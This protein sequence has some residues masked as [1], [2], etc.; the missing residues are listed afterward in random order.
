[1]SETKPINII[2]REGLAEHFTKVK[3]ELGIEIYGSEEYM[4]NTDV[5]AWLLN[6]R[7][8]DKS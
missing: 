5:I 2:L 4:S 6:Y 8:R 1:M 3:K 7:M